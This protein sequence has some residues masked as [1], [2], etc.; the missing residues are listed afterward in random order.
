MERRVT[1]PDPLTG[2]LVVS[3][4]VGPK[5]AFVV[6]I[7]LDG[8]VDELY[9]SHLG[10]LADFFKDNAVA[11]D[12]VL[13]SVLIELNGCAIT[14]VDSS[15]TEGLSKPPAFNVS[16][17]RVMRSNTEI[18]YIGDIACPQEELEKHK[19]SQI[20]FTVELYNPMRVS[21]AGNSEMEKLIKQ[22]DGLERDVERNKLMMIESEKKRHS[23]ASH[24]ETNKQL[25]SEREEDVLVLTAD[26]ATMKQI[27]GYK[28]NVNMKHLRRGKS[29]FCLYIRMQF[30]NFRVVY[31]PLP[32]VYFSLECDYMA[33]QDEN[34][35]LAAHVEHLQLGKYTGSML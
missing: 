8:V 17:V 2:D 9:E 14:V 12:N 28:N 1:S 18:W 7:A 29:K 25:L 30:F 15:D 13:L 16:N 22:I 33:A 34:R 10:P 24:L 32:T 31:F 4:T 19:V 5:P 6:H 3:S 35:S 26:N 21:S 23:L 11:E 20:P 27:L